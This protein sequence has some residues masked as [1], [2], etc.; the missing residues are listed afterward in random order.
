[1]K[2]KSLDDLPESTTDKDRSQD[3]VLEAYEQTVPKGKKLIKQALELD[4]DN[5][6]AYNYLAT[7]WNILDFGEV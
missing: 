4:S 6:D 1:M 2:G 5:A 7:L 3:L